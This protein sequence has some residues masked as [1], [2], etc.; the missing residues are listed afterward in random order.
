MT[1]FGVALDQM[2]RVRDDA[3][4][5]IGLAARQGYDSAWT[6]APASLERDA[7]Q[8]C[9][10]WWQ[11]SARERDGGMTVGIAVV[12]LPLW[13]IPA[14]AASAATLA[15][16]TGGRFVLGIGPS[17][18]HIPSFRERYGVARVSPVRLVREALLTL[19]PLLRGEP[20]TFDG[21]SVRLHGAALG[22]SAPAVPLYMSAL[23]PR[24][25]ALAGEL[26]DG[27]SLNWCTPEQIA[28]SRSAIDSASLSAGRSAGSVL[29]QSIR[30]SIDRDADVA[31]RRLGRAILHYALAR[32]GSSTTVGYRGHF[33]RMGFD[34]ELRRLERLRDDGATND[35]LA[36]AFP[37]EILSRVAYFGDAA[38]APTA[39]ARLSR[40][41][42]LALVRPIAAEGDTTAIAD[43]LTACAPLAVST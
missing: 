42:D 28:E 41:L 20:V 29:A 6:P 35:V 25:L 31:R 17:A 23:G 9:L 12:P 18:V 5:L 8:I 13:T 15:S 24:M 22:F 26:A 39:V 11:A 14:L 32:R 3:T 16:I 1:R 7:F 40:G 34:A 38:G 33:A 21:E 10:R 37:A 43:V 36:D 19:R 4:E 27:A 30:V 2:V